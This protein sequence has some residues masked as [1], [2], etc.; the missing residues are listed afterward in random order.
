MA[1]TVDLQ[2]AVTDF[3]AFAVEQGYPST[4]LW[5]APR[6]LMV[7]RGRY[8]VRRRD[9]EESERQANAVFDHGLAQD[10]G[11][12]VEAYCKT[13]RFT[14]CRVSVPDDGLDAKYRMIPESGVKMSVAVDPPAVVL[15]RNPLVWWLLLG[16]CSWSVA[17]L[18]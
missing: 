1:L 5:T 14:V 6:D 8:F 13:D 2:P 11:V 16:F 3:I 15:V 17:V 4:L 7:W 12:A 9:F 10:L 18:D